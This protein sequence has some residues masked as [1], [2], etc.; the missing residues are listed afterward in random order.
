MEA[1]LNSVKKIFDAALVNL[2]HKKEVEYVL[3]PNEF[4]KEFPFWFLVD[5]E[6]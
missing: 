5:K 1:I 3:L 4:G 6:N 2:L